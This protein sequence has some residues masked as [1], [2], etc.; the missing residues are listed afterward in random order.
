M[1]VFS[2]FFRTL[3]VYVAALILTSNFSCLAEVGK[4]WSFWTDPGG[5]LRNMGKWYKWQY[6]YKVLGKLF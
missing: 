6:L 3:Q 2:C 4:F 5:G 1:P